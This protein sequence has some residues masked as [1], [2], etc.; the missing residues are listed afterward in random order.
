MW[1]TKNHCGY[2]ILLFQLQC[3]RYTVSCIST[4]DNS[5]IENN[6]F[7]SRYNK[8]SYIAARHSTNNNVPT[9]QRRSRNN[10]SSNL[11]A[12][13][14]AHDDPNQC[15]LY[16]APSSIPNSG[17]GMYTTTPYTRGQTF[18]IPE[19]GI[20]LQDMTQHDIQNKFQAK[21]LSQ[22]P[23]A[24]QTLTNGALEVF[25]GEAIVPGLGMLANSHLGLVNARHSDLWKVQPFL[26]GT[27]TLTVEESIHYTREDVGR[28][29]YSWHGRVL[30][31]ATA[32]IQAG[33]EM[34]VSY[35]DEWFEAR[36]HFLGIVPGD[37]HFKEAD[38]MLKTFY[39]RMTDLHQEGYDQYNEELR[40]NEYDKLLKE[41]ELKDKRLRAA[42]PPDVEAVLAALARGTARF[43]AM[44]SIQSVEW[45]QEN[46]ACID[47]IV[48]GKS[49]IPQAGRGAFATRSIKK[50]GQIT[51][52]PVVT[53][54]RDQLV[55]WKNLNEDDT[56]FHLWEETGYQLLLNYCYGHANS[57]LLFFPYAPTVN[58]INHGSM[59]DANAEIRWSTSSAHKS[60]WLNA[61]LQETIDRLKTG[62]IF[63]IIATKDIH[64]GEEVLLHYG[65][66]WEDSW[67]QHMEEWELEGNE[68]S[69]DA[70]GGRTNL[71]ERLGHPTT[72]DLNK[73]GDSII[74]TREEQ[75]SDPYPAHITTVCV[76][77]PPEECTPPSSDGA[78]VDS[79]IECQS[80]WTLTFGTEKVCT[81]LARE[82][83]EGMDWYTANVEVT[84]KVLKKI[85]HHFVTYMPRYAIRLVDKPYSRDQ[86]ALETFRHVIGLDDGIFP[87]HWM[88]IEEDD[89]KNSLVNEEVNSSG[90]DESVV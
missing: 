37:R 59:E 39:D 49:K 33:E 52:T 19:I 81:I 71:T 45:L 36:E 5:F 54:D 83:I 25:Y 9:Q 13:H 10:S 7:F 22:Y 69:R 2:W 87:S 90:D 44:K 24:A 74:K 62:L 48:A 28:G 6:D 64:R 79:D 4:I 86:Y 53:L 31:E 72:L 1:S 47:N 77:D 21:L 40:K 61:T 56:T 27:D 16:L 32:D 30:F 23:W 29:A 57:S 41:V 78:G 50:G 12:S 46:G 15:T 60:E 43:S 68:D 51:T 8:D 18:P 88:D 38:Q 67:K 11:N 89:D 76:F 84:S 34:F 65:K 85:T 75:R 3:L 58:F 66:E 17:L 70:V 42:F 73:S 26:D 35:G 82:T 80:R 63:D 20:L 55:L 14:D